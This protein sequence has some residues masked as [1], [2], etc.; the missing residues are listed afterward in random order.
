LLNSSAALIFFWTIFGLITFAP[1]KFF[2]FIK[3]EIENFRF[4][5]KNSFYYKDENE[6]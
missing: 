6:K 2:S 5:L 1:I 4:K 3:E